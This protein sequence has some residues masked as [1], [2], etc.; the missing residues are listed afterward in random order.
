MKKIFE[1]ALET[2]RDGQIEHFYEDEENGTIDF[3]LRGKAASYQLRLFT[4]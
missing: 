1:T 2:V 4:D 3:T